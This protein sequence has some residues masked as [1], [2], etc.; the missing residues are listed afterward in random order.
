[1]AGAE[2]NAL[3]IML[4]GTIG[5]GKSVTANTILGDQ[6]FDSKIAAQFVTKSCQEAS[7]K[8]KGRELLIIA[9]PGFFD[10]KESQ[11]TI[12]NEI[13]E[14]LFT[15]H[16]GLHAIIL[17]IQLGCYTQ[18][19]QQTVA[20]IKNLFGEAVMKYMIILFTHK[21]ELEDQSLRDYVRK[22][23]KLQSLIKECGDRYCVFSNRTDQAK[24]ESQVQEL[25]ELIDKMVQNNRGAYFTNAA[26]K[27]T[28]LTCP[29]STADAQDNALRIVLVGKTGSGKSATANT[30]LGEQVFESR[31]A[32][33]AV[34]KTCQK[35]SRKWKGREL[36]VVDTPGLFDTKE[37]KDTT[38]RE[39]SR[40][41]LASC[42]GPHAIVLVLR[43][44][45]YTQEEQQAMALVKN[46][47]GKAAMKYMIILFTCRDELG[48]QSLSDF[49]KDA[50]VNLRS[51]L[52]ECGERC[53]AI[54]NNKYTEQAEKEAQVQELLELIENMVQNNRGAYFTNAAHKGTELNCPH[55]PANAQYK[56]LRI[57]LVGKTGS[58]KSATA[59]TILG[60]KV[61]ESKIAAE[62]V[63][64]TCQKASRKWKGRELLVVDTPG[65]FDT[66]ETLN[67]TCREICRC[68]L[69]SCPGPHAIILVLRLGRY[70]QEEQQTVA[71]LKA[72]F[73]EAAMKYMIILFT[74]K[75]ELEDQSLR[76]FLENA[77]VNLGSFIKECGDR[78][79]AFD[80]S[81]NTEQAEKEAQVQE[82]VE[83]IE[84]M[85]QNN[86]GTY[87]SDPIYKNTM[88][89][90]RRRE[91]VLRKI[92]ADQLK[93]DIQKVEVE[94]AQACKNK[95][96]EKERI[97]KLLKM[98]YKEK[99]R[100]AREEARNSIFRDKRDGNMNF[101]LRISNW[102]KK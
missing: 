37:T 76:D 79:C 64:R 43:L 2:G 98:E 70:T 100:H 12:L 71:L 16:H 99:L 77:D 67:T 39:I 17:V 48:D 68:V 101:P 51:L 90:L 1:M 63:T 91:E 85:V 31:I 30:I 55:C 102:F 87:F 57:V 41:L 53:C 58:G 21:E 15:S 8:W 47:F 80:N 44:G 66:K 28:E 95:M 7:Q 3:R 61:F 20:L 18:E 10:T 38:C 32:A 86:E 78:Y 4:V 59:N 33:P 46:L 40:C 5:S 25:V 89:R 88:E 49:L 34:T 82:L 84:N 45:C 69:A 93:T 94:C 42:P 22:V 60:E 14:Y 23:E 11:S 75:E 73:G 9:T 54:S 24:K 62:A 96:Q 36:L 74:R 52:Q 29:Y 81:R 65:L 27:G 72:L 56:T 6:V 26:H 19:E 50:D 97:I 13:K 35:A 92:Y 83:L